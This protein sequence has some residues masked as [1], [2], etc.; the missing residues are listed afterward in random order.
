MPGVPPWVSPPAPPDFGRSVNPISTMGGRL[1]PPNNTGTLDFQTFLRPCLTMHSSPDLQ[2]KSQ[3]F[4]QMR[5]KGRQS[6][7]I[8]RSEVTDL[9]IG[10]L[11]FLAKKAT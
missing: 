7:K 3:I 10:T 1:C 8:D 5:Q 6:L 2:Q 4:V 9:L 11:T